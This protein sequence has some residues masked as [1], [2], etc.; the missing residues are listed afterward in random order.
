M[1]FNLDDINVGAQLK[2]GTGI[3]PA[4]GE[5]VTRINGS[6]GMEGPVVI[7]APGSFPTPYATLNLAP[8]VNGDSPPPFT[9]GGLPMG[10][11]NPYSLC[12]SAN[13]NS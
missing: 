7:G 8:L 1:S 6:A 2:C 9:P 4:I 5:G 13:L 12:C 3:F 10:L 11:S